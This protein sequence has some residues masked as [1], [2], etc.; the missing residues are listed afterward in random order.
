MVLF[1]HAVF[2]L[3]IASGACDEYGI[4]SVC[5]EVSEVL[6]GAAN[7][8]MR[9]IKSEEETGNIAEE[10]TVEVTVEVNG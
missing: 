10:V 9:N 7:Q 5:G 2:F 4:Y 6:Y 3:I 8:L 1:Y